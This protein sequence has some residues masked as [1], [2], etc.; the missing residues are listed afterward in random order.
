M[1]DGGI[2]NLGEQPGSEMVGNYFGMVGGFSRG[3]AIYFDQGSRFLKV[4]S[5]YS[6]NPNG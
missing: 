4:A 3:S 2:Y 1:H 5:N 6:D